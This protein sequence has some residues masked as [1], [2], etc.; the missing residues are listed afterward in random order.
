MLTVGACEDTDGIVVDTIVG[1][2][3]GR[4]GMEEEEEEREEYH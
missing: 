1:I 4:K 3:E 2:G